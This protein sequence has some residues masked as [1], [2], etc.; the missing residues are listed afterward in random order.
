VIQILYSYRVQASIL[1]RHN[2]SKKDK[3]EVLVRTFRQLGKAYDFNFN[4]ETTDRIVC[5]QLVY[6]AYPDIPWPTEYI[7]GRYTISPDNI[8][9]KTTEGDFFEVVALIRDGEVISENKE[10]VMATLIRAEE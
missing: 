6:L 7:A 8:A 5:S 2:L 4:V 1:R 9:A 10:D 3:G